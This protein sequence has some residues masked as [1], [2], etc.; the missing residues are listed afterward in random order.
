MQTQATNAEARAEAA[1]AELSELQ[2]RLLEEQ[3]T[4]EALRRQMVFIMHGEG[5][6]WG[7]AGGSPGSAP[8]SPLS[9]FARGTDPRP[10]L[11]FAETLAA[12]EELM[13]READPEGERTSLARVL[14]TV[15]I[16]ARA[17][18]C[19]L[20]RGVEVRSREPGS[21]YA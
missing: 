21:A 1:E 4:V 6:S 18:H 7:D 20:A 19:R 11:R 9:P 16:A 2:G 14:H 17:G 13:L 12:V 5:G 3:A 10:E 8:G 15:S